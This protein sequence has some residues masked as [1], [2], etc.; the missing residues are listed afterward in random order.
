MEQKNQFLLHFEKEHLFVAHLF[1]ITIITNS[2]GP[3]KADQGQSAVTSHLCGP[4][5][6]HSSMAEKD[7]A[8]THSTDACMYCTAVQEKKKVQ[9]T[10]AKM[11]TFHYLPLSVNR[12]AS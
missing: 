3:V 9:T 4:A 8:T 12:S 10:Y 11:Q 1:V 7:W 6:V 2:Q 5:V